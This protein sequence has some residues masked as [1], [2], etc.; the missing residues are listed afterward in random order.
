MSYPNPT[1]PRKPNLILLGA[2]GFF[3]GVLT[4]VLFV[5]LS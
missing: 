4:V 2:L 5:L 3:L 1:P